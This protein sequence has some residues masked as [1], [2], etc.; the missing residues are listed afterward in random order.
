MTS[1]LIVAIVVLL[2]IAIWQLTKIFD[3]TQTK[4]FAGEEYK[5]EVATDKDNNIN[6]YL[7]FGFLAFIYIFTIYSCM[8]WGYMPLL[9]NSASEHGKDVDMLMWISMGLI[10][11]VQIVTQFLLHY[12][13]F[14]YRGNKNHKAIFFADNDKL[15]LFGPSFL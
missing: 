14:I 12:F 6:G 9:A 2:G 1:L 4:A 10:F 11:F 7:M 15:N 13:A 3:L 5:S 8:K